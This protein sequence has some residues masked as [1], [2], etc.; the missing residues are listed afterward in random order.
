MIKEFL[1]FCSFYEKKKKIN[2]LY[3]Q[4]MQARKEEEAIEA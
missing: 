2:W 3:N 1:A 4:Y